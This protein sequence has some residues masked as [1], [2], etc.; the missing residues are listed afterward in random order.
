[1]KVKVEVDRLAA[2]RA[3]RQ[4]YGP[5][6]MTLH[7]GDLTAAERAFLAEVALEHAGV[8]DLTRLQD[9]LPRVRGAEQ[10][11]WARL[12]P[13]PPSPRLAEVDEPVKAARAWLWW[14]VACYR[15]AWDAARAEPR[16][17]LGRT[18][19]LLGWSRPRR[20]ATPLPRP[21]NARPCPGLSPRGARGGP[22]AARPGPSR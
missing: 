9:P 8:I 11:T 15:L 3:G 1:M 19:E 22:P 18:P 5:V 16:T 2:L 10:L 17:R 20:P 12:G 4:H 7:P 13:L 6:V 14:L 21:G